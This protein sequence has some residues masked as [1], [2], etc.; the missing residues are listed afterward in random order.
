MSWLKGRHLYREFGRS[1]ARILNRLHASYGDGVNGDLTERMGYSIGNCGQN[2]KCSHWN[3]G[4]DKNDE[5]VSW[6]EPLILG[7]GRDLSYLILEMPFNNLWAHITS[8]MK[9]RTDPWWDELDM[10]NQWS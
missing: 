6:E 8:A 10:D 9:H 5:Y 7:R 2:L 1:R 4:D 3:Y